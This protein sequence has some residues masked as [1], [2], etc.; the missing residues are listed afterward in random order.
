MKQACVMSVSMLVFLLHLESHC[1]LLTALSP[2]ALSVLANAAG[3]PGSPK[4]G[5]FRRY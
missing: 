1:H 4:K 2:S 5:N 3:T